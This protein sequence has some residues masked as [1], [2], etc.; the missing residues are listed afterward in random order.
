VFLLIFSLFI[1]TLL[2]GYGVDIG[3]ENQA[4]CTQDLKAAL[5]YLLGEINLT[6]NCEYPDAKLL[7]EKLYSAC[8]TIGF[9][10]F[11]V[12]ELE[13]KIKKIKNEKLATRLGILGS[14]SFLTS[15]INVNFSAP[16][17]TLPFSAAHEM[18][19]LFGIS[20]E[21]EASFFGYLASLATK[22]DAIMYSAYLSAFEYV[23]SALVRANRD[24]YLEVFEKLPEKAKLDIKSYKDFYVRNSTPLTDASDKINEELLN[25]VDKNGSYDYG[26][27]TNLL[28]SYLLSSG[29][30]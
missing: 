24:F 4:I 29:V 20:G 27:F 19:H 11:T 14:Y 15:E 28:V 1:N 22:D 23:G 13:P 9:S 12:T 5:I 8:K 21:A 7:S 25:F 6:Q 2:I 30:L 3:I 10:G 18:A 17:Y 26:S 16:S